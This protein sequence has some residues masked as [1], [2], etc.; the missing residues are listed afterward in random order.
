MPKE[1]EELIEE[2]LKLHV[3]PAVVSDDPRVEALRDYLQEFADFP[4]NRPVP[5]APRMKYS[6]CRSSST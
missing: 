1:I 2:R 4:E 5:H 6:T 3:E